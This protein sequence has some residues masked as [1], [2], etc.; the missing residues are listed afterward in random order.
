MCRSSASGGGAIL[1]VIEGDVHVGVL[2][3][4]L[5]ARPLG[6]SSARSRYDRSGLIARTH[7]AFDRG[8]QAGLGPVAGEEDIRP[9]CA[10][11]RPFARSAPASRRRSRGF[12]LTI[13]Q[14]GRSAASPVSA[15]ASRQISAAS[16]SR[17]RSISRSALLMVTESR[18]G[19]ANSHS[20]SALTTPRIARLAARRRDMEMDIE[21]GA[22]FVWRRQAGKQVLRDPWRRA[23]DHGVVRAELSCV[24]RRNRAR[25]RAS[26]RNGSPEGDRR[27]RTA[28]PRAARK[29][30]AGS[31][32]LPRES[33][34][35][36]QRVAGLAPPRRASRA[37]KPRSARP[38]FPRD[39]C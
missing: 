2:M 36:E 18:S 24:R 35:G 28:T 29:A 1:R 3:S 5:T 21:N 10:R 27:S 17:G 15:A 9:L 31:M 11:I 20:I 25:R 13:C 32:K 8:R 6:A 14:G 4:A 7:G 33:M 19:K 39:L 12:S 30:S 38:S 23:E 37:A 22:K 26:P 16:S 34:A